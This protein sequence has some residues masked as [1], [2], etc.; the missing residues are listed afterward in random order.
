[1][2]F[3][4]LVILILLS[5][6]LPA[7]ARDD[8]RYAQSPLRE[9]MK[10][11]KDKFGQPCCDTA[12]GHEVEGWA[13]GPDGYR[14][15]VQ[16]RWMDVPPTALLTGPNLL[17]FARVWLYWENGAPQVRCFLPGAGG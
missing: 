17:G 15:K 8:G 13:F 7:V 3:R 16:G 14:V 10:S 6:I 2:M 12:D 4:V 1:M 5:I 11:L 9:W